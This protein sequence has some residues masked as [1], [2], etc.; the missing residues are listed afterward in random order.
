MSILPPQKELQT[1]ALEK[2]EDIM[3]AAPCLQIGKLFSLRRLI[4]SRCRGIAQVYTRETNLR[5]QPN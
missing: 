5:L 2:L 1:L 4:V 3:W